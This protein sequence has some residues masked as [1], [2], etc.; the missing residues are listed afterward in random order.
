M[1][2]NK[3]MTA[4]HCPTQELWNQV[5]D[6]IKSKISKDSWDIYKSNSCL[7]ESG[8]YYSGLDF[9]QRERYDIIE[10]ED[11]LKELPKNHFSITG[12]WA[13]KQKA[14]QEACDWFNKMYHMGAHLKGS[15]TYLVNDVNTGRGGKLNHIIPAGFEEITLEQFKE[16]ILKEKGEEKQMNKLPNN[17]AVEFEDTDDFRDTVVRELNRFA[18]YK[19]FNGT[20]DEDDYYYGVDG[21]ETKCALLS[22]W[23][24]T[25]V[26]LTLTDFKNALASSSTI[27][28]YRV[29]KTIPLSSMKE[30]TI[31]TTSSSFAECAENPE[32]FSP[33]YK[34]NV[35]AGDWVCVIA[36]EEWAYKNVGDVFK[37]VKVAGNNLYFDRT[38]AVNINRVRKATPA[39][40]KANTTVK[41]E[42]YEA[43][44]KGTNVEIEGQLYDKEELKEF[45]QFIEKHSRQIKGLVFG[46]TGQHQ[47]NLEKLK[48][49]K[50]KL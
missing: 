27:T 7:L 43:K 46:C 15:F 21:A 6:K 19:K 17:W 39:E 29:I 22:K 8:R 18:G 4:I 44:F 47:M 25:P 20:V 34:E 13:I 12:K 38:C 30:G 11:F 40:I 50:D 3:E 49:I 36:N 24:N 45:I 5:Y 41:I 33:I 48:E 42:G 31:I 28:G 23:R 26:V 1:T 10:A 32:F 2:R 37:I 16:F 9:Y 35:S 14:G